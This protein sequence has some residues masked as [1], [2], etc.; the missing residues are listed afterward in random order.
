MGDTSE[1]NNGSDKV[2]DDT[3]QINID[4]AKIERGWLGAGN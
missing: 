4:P 2:I 3:P 1:A